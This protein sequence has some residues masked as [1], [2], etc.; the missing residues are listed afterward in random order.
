M[1]LTLLLVQVL[2][3]AS[4]AFLH[5]IKTA[6]QPHPKGSDV[7]LSLSD[8]VVG[9]LRVPDIVSDEFFKLALPSFL[10]VSVIY[11]LNFS[12]QSVYIFNKNIITR[13]QDPFL[14]LS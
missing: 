6:L 4:P 11:V 13:Y 14:L 9:V 7:L 1:E 2:D 10:E 3:E 8:L 5:L 12:H